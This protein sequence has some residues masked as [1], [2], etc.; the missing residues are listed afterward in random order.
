[1]LTLAFS[2]IVW[3]IAYKWNDVTG[4]DQGLPEIPYPHLDWM[5][6]LPG[7]SDLSIGSRFYLL[8][9]ALVAV[10]LAAVHRVIRSPFGR[11]RDDDPRQSGA[12]PFLAST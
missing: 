11:V 4:G 3:A 10:S 1:M 7:F 12:P 2:Q 9:L 6:A 5:S 8:T